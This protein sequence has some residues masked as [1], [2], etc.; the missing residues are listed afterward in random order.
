MKDLR[1]R[2][3]LD[4]PGA[5]GSTY[6]L[7]VVRSPLCW[8]PWV[9]E[10]CVFVVEGDDRWLGLVAVFL[11][12]EDHSIC[13]LASMWTDPGSRGLGL[14]RRLLESGIE[15]ARDR[16]ATVVRLGV[17][18]DNATALRLYRGA[19]FEPTGAREPLHSEPSKTV[20][21]MERSLRRS[22]NPIC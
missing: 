15:W 22:P 6:E 11:D 20:I 19:G 9:D 1:L 12:G 16:G 13:H 21:Y 2:A 18:E 7:E 17:V 3:L 4:S 14:G 8:R 5:F 10:G